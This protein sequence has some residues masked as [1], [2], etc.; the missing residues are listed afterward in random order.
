MRKSRW[1]VEKKNRRH[2]NKILKKCEWLWEI[3]GES[4][5]L[6]TKKKQ[7]KKKR[8]HRNA[9]VR[10]KADFCLPSLSQEQFWNSRRAL[11]QRVVLPSNRE[12]EGGGGGGGEREGGREGGRERERE[13]ERILDVTEIPSNYQ[14]A[15]SVGYFT[16]V[17]QYTDNDSQK[18]VTKSCKKKSSSL[19]LCQQKR[20]RKNHGNQKQE[21]NGKTRLEK[22]KLLW[23]YFV[24][25]LRLYLL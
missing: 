9:R 20:M 4:W 12:R 14:P 16:T 25:P 11:L 23:V 3:Q 8:R 21:K 22:Q 24:F 18:P 13:R 17:Q 5:K 1:K 10:N 2:L 6:K 7:Q 15:V 19:K